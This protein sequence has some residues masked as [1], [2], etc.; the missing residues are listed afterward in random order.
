MAGGGVEGG[1]DVV[2]KLK[3]GHEAFWRLF[4]PA[5]AALVNLASLLHPLDRK[6]LHHLP[7]RGNRLG[8]RGA[9]KGQVKE[10]G[11]CPF[12]NGLDAF[13]IAAFRFPE[14]LHGNL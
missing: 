9:M 8:C 2:A 6:R 7:S 5:L 4:R 1:K 3:Q 11:S 14:L 13:L 10:D 12:K